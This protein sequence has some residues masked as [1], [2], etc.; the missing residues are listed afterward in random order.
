MSE[1]QHV[2]EIVED[3]AGPVNPELERTE[4]DDLVESVSAA[5]EPTPEPNW[6]RFD[7]RTDFDAGLAAAQAA[8]A[9][10]KCIVLPTDTVYGIGANAFSADAVQALLDAKH[11]GRDMPP[12]VLIAEPAMLAA[13]GS[14]V[15]GSP[16]RLADAFWPGALTLIVAMQP[17]LRLD[18]GETRGS[19][20]L[21]VPDHDLARNLL[22]RTGPLAVSSANVSGQSPSTSIDDA[23]E[24]LGNSVAVYLD[25]GPTPGETPSTI[26]EFVTTSDGKVV[27]DGVLTLV[28]LRNVVPDVLDLDGNPPAVPSHEAPTSVESEPAVSEPAPSEEIVADSS[29]EQ[30]SLSEP[31]E[32]SPASPTEG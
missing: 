29:A 30:A 17:A 9:D 27:R 16:S 24:Q 20:A 26:V 2:P 10:G 18:L 6:T 5:P 12:P 32:P 8:L 22:R 11:R 14:E 31:E 15:A 3:L 7:L 13:L 28:E 1:Q 19:I 4:A 25:A 23:I 21:R